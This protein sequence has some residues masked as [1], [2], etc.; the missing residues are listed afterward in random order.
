MTRNKQ[1]CRAENETHRVMAQ[2]ALNIKCTGRNMCFGGS[3]G[4]SKSN[5]R[6]GVS[7][8]RAVGILAHRAAGYKQS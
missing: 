1:D 3:F 5:S 4:A 6:L 8:S 7:G 2:V